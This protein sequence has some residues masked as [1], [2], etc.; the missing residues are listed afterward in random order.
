MKVGSATLSNEMGVSVK[1]ESDEKGYKWHGANAD[2]EFNGKLVA[3]DNFHWL[4]E[5][6]MYSYLSYIYLYETPHD[7]YI[8]VVVDMDKCNLFVCHD[9]EDI[10][11]N[12]SSVVPY[13]SKDRME[14]FIASVDEYFDRKDDPLWK[15]E[16]EGAEEYEVDKQKE[17]ES[18]DDG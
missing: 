7:H 4:S 15:V 17:K 12:A 16:I 10:I 11:A 14:T 3:I 9:K 18:N 5:E 6:L 1:S 13:A 2:I 8:L